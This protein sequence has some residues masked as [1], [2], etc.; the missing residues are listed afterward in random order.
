M[1]WRVR[2]GS[3]KQLGRKSLSLA[4]VALEVVVGLAIIAL[5]GHN[6]AW[7]YD[8]YAD[9]CVPR[10]P[11]RGGVRLDRTR[12]SGLRRSPEAPCAVVR[13]DR[14]RASGLRRAWFTRRRHLSWRRYC[15]ACFR[16][17]HGPFWIGLGVGCLV[18]RPAMLAASEGAARWLIMSSA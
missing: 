2:I 9:A 11:P 6:V 15:R 5:F 18:A 16:I 8:D 1:M 3:L 10:A 13:L 17:G 7:C 14:A 12:A 4:S